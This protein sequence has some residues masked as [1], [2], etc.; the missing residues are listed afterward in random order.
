MDISRRLEWLLGLNAREANQQQ[1]R[2][3]QLMVQLKIYET[4]SQRKIVSVLRQ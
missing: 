1:I 4:I 2:E 3:L